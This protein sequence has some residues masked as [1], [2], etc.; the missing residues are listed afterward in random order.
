MGK[1]TCVLLLPCTVNLESVAPFANVTEST[2]TLYVRRVASSEKPFGFCTSSTTSSDPP[3]NPTPVTFTSRNETTGS[4][5]ACLPSEAQPIVAST[6]AEA[7]TNTKRVM[8]GIS[9]ML[10]ITC[11][12]Q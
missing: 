12:Q 3:F 5:N 11:H 9:R 1:C 6:A 7:A 4:L 8:T 2:S 10:D